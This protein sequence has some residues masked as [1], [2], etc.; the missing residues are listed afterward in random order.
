[1]CGMQFFTHQM[2]C[3]PSSMVRFRKRIGEQGAELML[4][5]TVDVGLKVGAVKESSLREVV[6]DSTVMEKNICFPTDS[7]LLER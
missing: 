1:F 2:P 4:S 6:V 5:L 3:D 7:K